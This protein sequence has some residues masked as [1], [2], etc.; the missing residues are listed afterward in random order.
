MALES[1]TYISGLVDTNPSGSDSI[2]QGDDHLRLIK[3]VLKN[4]LPNADEA[5][6]GIH[7]GGTAPS[8]TTAGLIWFDTSNNLL[9]IRNEADSGWITFL[10]EDG[11][12]IIKVSRLEDTSSASIRSTSMTDAATF[13]VVKASAT[14]NLLIQANLF[15]G[16]WAYAT[17]QTGEAQ[18]YNATDAAAI[19]SNWSAGGQWSSSSW[20]S[21]TNNEI[22]SWTTMTVLESTPLSAGTKSIKIRANCS[23]PSD[24][25]I[26][27]SMS[28]LTVWEIE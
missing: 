14:S 26:S 28:S 19:G 25:G 1:A 24:G 23:N 11:N 8:P 5:I 15:G 3:S 2:S 17:A 4:T 27:T 16:L 6:N 22:R 21:S 9:K 20:S 18:V 12:N 13:S 7:T 10:S